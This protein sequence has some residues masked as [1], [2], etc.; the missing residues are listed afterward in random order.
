MQ[1]S[2]VAP[3]DNM[4]TVQFLGYS[5]FAGTLEE[6]Q[7]VVTEAVQE[8]KKLHI[9]TVNPEMLVVRNPDFRSVL[10]RAEIRLPDGIGVVWG[11]KF[12]RCGNLERLPGIE[13]AE[14][15][16]EWGR[17]KG[18]RFYFLGARESVVAQAVENLL[19]R[20][21]GL[22]I[23][24]FHH[25]YFED[26]AAV[27]ADI[28]ASC[29]QVLFVGMGVPRQEMWIARHRDVLPA[30]IFMGVGGSFDVWAGRVRR[31]PLCFRCLGL[32][33]LWRV[34][35]EPRRVRRVVPAFARFG[36]L[37]LKERWRRG[38]YNTS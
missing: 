29:P 22:C 16:M 6:L 36:I 25:G 13:V 34:V 15:L 7:G 30:Q 27:L 14:A 20:Y 11:A 19:R 10:E 24:G 35:C 32:E 5:F 23:A 26:D 9:V 17:E 28:A 18:W 31:A 38:W 2:S 37:L 1:K 4:K 8:G 21:P 3:L 33:W 12:L